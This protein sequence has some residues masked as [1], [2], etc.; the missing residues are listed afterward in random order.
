MILPI[1]FENHNQSENDW[2]KLF[3][4]IIDSEVFQDD[5]LCR[6]WIWC[7]CKASYRDMTYGPYKIKRGQFITGRNNG[8]SE[9]HV[10]PSKFY[11]GLN[12]IAEMGNIAVVTDK[13][14]TIVTVC[15]YNDYQGCGEPLRSTHSKIAPPE[16]NAYRGG[17]VKLHRSILESEA[18]LVDWPFRLW[19]WCICKTNFRPGSYYQTA[20]RPGQFVTGRASGAAQLG[21]TES[22]WYR[23]MQKLAELGIISMDANNRRTIVTV[24]NYSSYQKD[25]EPQR[26]ASGQPMIQHQNTRERSKEFKNGVKETPIPPSQKKHRD[27]WELK[28]QDLRNTER[29]LAWTRHT[30]LVEETHANQLKVLAAS[31]RA[32]SVEKLGGKPPDNR[33]AY[34][35]SIVRDGNW[36]VITDEDMDRAKLR[37]VTWQ[38]Q[39]VQAESPVDLENLFAG[40]D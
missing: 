27:G 25:E 38:R 21:V 33:V 13:A 29:I 32:I 4:R 20:V 19:I 10:H 5:W 35:V 16:N 24:S 26:T 8:A 12:R 22:K 14:R 34:F 18:F 37:H 28:D 2:I 7:L 40:V 1:P 11:R 30:R 9:L 23:G 39:Q 36:M 31:E 3:R 15:N 6:F 17:W